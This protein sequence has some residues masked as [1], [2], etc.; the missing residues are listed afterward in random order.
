MYKFLKRGK[1]ITP[2]ANFEILADLCSGIY[3]AAFGKILI[4]KF[5]IF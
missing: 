1:S 5:K 2:H 4:I 3:N